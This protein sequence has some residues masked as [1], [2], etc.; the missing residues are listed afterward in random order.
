MVNELLPV[1]LIFHNCPLLVLVF[2]VDLSLLLMAIT[3]KMFFFIIFKNQFISL[4]S[5]A[6]SQYYDILI[7]LEEPLWLHYEYIHAKTNGQPLIHSPLHW[8]FLTSTFRLRSILIS[9]NNFYPDKWD[10][11]CSNPIFCY[12]AQSYLLWTSIIIVILYSDS[13]IMFH[14]ISD[15]WSTFSMPK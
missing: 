13:I 3:A 14:H 11:K 15:D 8:V 2:Y 7:E 10:T 6:S 12:S 5:M 9:R 1:A 4:E